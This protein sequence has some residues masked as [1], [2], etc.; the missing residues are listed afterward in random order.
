MSIDNARLA[1]VETKLTVVES[2]IKEMHADLG[3]LLEKQ[4]EISTV[5]SNWRAGAVVLFALGAAASWVFDHLVALKTFLL[6]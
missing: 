1:V 4:A 6:K 5:L 3:K 2:D